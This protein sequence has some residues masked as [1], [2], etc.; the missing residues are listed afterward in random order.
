MRI[1]SYIIFGVCVCVCM[2]ARVLLFVLF[3]LLLLFFCFVLSRDFDLLVCELFAKIFVWK[4][5]LANAHTH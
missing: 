4:S 2:C 1:D 3:S 5:N